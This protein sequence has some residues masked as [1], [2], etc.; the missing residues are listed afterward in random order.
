[1]F[2]VFNE[3]GQ[4]DRFATCLPVI[5]L[6][7]RDFP[8]LENTLDAVFNFNLSANVSAH[9]FLYISIIFHKSDR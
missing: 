6:I 1:L 2:V 3:L 7:D 8:N 5:S 9:P 4:A